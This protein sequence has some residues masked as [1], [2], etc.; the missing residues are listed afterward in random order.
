MIC[1]TCWEELPFKLHQTKIRVSFVIMDVQQAS[2]LLKMLQ[3][4][5]VVSFSVC[6]VWCVCVCV[7]GF[8]FGWVGG[9][10]GGWM[11]GWVGGW[12]GRRVSEQTLQLTGA[13][14]ST[15]AMLG[16]SLA[17]VVFCVCLV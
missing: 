13:A 12:V 15:N 16:A 7:R 11:G 17:S 1:S 9:S 2:E 5:L 3:R 8:W 6:L 10:V 14:G 4:L